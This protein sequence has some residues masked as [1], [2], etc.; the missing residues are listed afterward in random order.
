MML[1]THVEYICLNP[2]SAK[3][4]ILYSIYMHFFFGRMIGGGVSGMGQLYMKEVGLQRKRGNKM[5]K[6]NELIKF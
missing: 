2:F 5:L 3:G 4:Q 6:V 1:Q